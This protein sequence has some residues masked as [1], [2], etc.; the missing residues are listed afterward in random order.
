METGVHSFRSSSRGSSM[1]RKA[2]KTNSTRHSSASTRRSRCRRTSRTRP[3]AST[4]RSFRTSPSRRKMRIAF[5][6]NTRHDKGEFQVEY[7]PEHTIKLVKHAIEAAGWEYLQIE[8]D[9]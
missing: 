8:A 4:R 3:S 1:R 5:C 6:C 2:E 7:E 9:E